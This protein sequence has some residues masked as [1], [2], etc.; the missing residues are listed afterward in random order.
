MHREIGNRYNRMCM[1]DHNHFNRELQTMID[2]KWKAI[3][4]LPK[5]LQE[6]ALI[7][8]DGPMPPDAFLPS[9]TPPVPGFKTKEAEIEYEYDEA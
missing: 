9:W 1:I 4:A 7:E 3:N 6:E 5:E 8:D 2:M